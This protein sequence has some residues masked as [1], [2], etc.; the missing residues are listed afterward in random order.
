MKIPAARDNAAWCRE[1]PFIHGLIKDAS[2]GRCRG[3]RRMR[4]YDTHT[5]R[6]ADRVLPTPF[7]V[8][9]DAHESRPELVCTGVLRHLPGKRLVCSGTRGGGEPVVAKIFLDPSGADRHYRRELQGIKALQEAGIA[10]PELLFQGRLAD[11]QAPVLLLREMHGFDNLSE[12]LERCGQDRRM[13]T[14]RPVVEAIAGLHAAGLKQRDIHPGN[15]L[16]SGSRVMII[17][18]DDIEK[19]GPA[20]L[21]HRESLSNLALFFAQFH[22]AFDALAPHLMA[23]YHACRHWPTPSD[24]SESIAIAIQRWRKWRLK[25]FLPKIQR[26]C[27]A[28]FVQK[29]WRRFMACDRA[30]YV[31]AHQA[32]LDDPDAFIET[33]TVLKAGN[34]GTVAKLSIDGREIVVKRYNIKSM[35]HAI[36]RGLR[37]S[38]AMV[39]WENAHRL[40][41]LGIR[42]P[43]PLAVIEERW[44]IRRKRAFFFMAHRPG[45]TIDQ[46]LRGALDNPQAVNH[47]LDLLGDLLKQLAAA[48]ISHGDCKATNFLLSSQ[49]LYLVDLDGMRA[50]RFKSAHRRAFRR[51]MD[52]LLCNWQDLPQVQCGLEARIKKALEEEV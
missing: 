42:T 1:V 3:K 47:Y 36:S 7:Q 21:S 26:S 9:L 51:D 39:S 41:F 11:G 20:P 23:V 32:L 49:G 16:L 52:R 44:G 4:C 17:D 15:F 22:P 2:A 40:R 43:R 50:H 38:R 14:L 25:R 33:G 5:L 37:P 10:T 19:P 30:W 12:R 31:P 28:F 48:L 35:A 8:I 6:G 13:E 18:G 27:T 45:I 29:Q 46:A 34:R 24:T